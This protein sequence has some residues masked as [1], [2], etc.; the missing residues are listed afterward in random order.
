MRVSHM[1]LPPPPSLLP[2]NELA[3]CKGAR[4]SSP[5]PTR[6]RS[7]S[8]FPGYPLLS[9]RCLVDITC[10]CH[11]DPNYVCRAPCA[12]AYMAV[13]RAANGGICVFHWQRLH[14]S[15]FFHPTPEPQS[16]LPGQEGESAS[17]H[18]GSMHIVSAYNSGSRTPYIVS[19]D[20]SGPATPRQPTE[21]FLRGLRGALLGDTPP[22]WSSSSLSNPES[23]QS[24]S[25]T[26]P[27]STSRSERTPDERHAAGVLAE[28]AFSSVA[29]PGL[30]L[31]AGDDAVP[32][33]MSTPVPVAST[34]AMKDPAPP[35]T[36]AF[37]RSPNAPPTP[38]LPQR[39]DLAVAQIALS[40]WN[41]AQNPG[42]NC[43]DLGMTFHGDDVLFTTP[44]DVTIRP[45]P[46]VFEICQ[47]LW[48][49]RSS[50]PTP[51]MLRGGQHW[52]P[53]NGVWDF[54]RI[55]AGEV[56]PG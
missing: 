26:I 15:N 27:S 37:P 50:L 9:E 24:R 34:V 32:Q 41:A 53:E 46:E 56:P 8:L 14:G 55:R 6:F 38:F 23:Q 44:T 12:Q 22:S 49:R 18:Q 19:S 54:R 4:C 29:G 31:T 30:E 2:R 47:R 20:N 35:T 42:S 43:P 21:S 45:W 11:S 52:E 33:R 51:E 10:E 40:L 1:A 3:L 48:A 5:L 25:P 36:I 39:S 17:S 16:G 13:N 28:L 7:R